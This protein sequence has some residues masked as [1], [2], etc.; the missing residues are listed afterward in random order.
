M[1]FDCVFKTPVQKRKKYGLMALET[2]LHLAN[3]VLATAE[4]R[5]N[6]KLIQWLNREDTYQCK[7]SR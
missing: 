7:H 2:W 6:S 5:A 1:L 3:G 4:T